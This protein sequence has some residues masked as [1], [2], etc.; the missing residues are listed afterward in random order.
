[1]LSNGY[2][3]WSGIDSLVSTPIYLVICFVFLFISKPT[4]TRCYWIKLA[5]RS[6]IR[7]TNLLGYDP[8][9]FVLN[10]TPCACGSF[11]MSIYNRSSFWR[12]YRGLKCV[13]LRCYFKPIFHSFM[14]LLL[15][16]I[17]SCIIATVALKS[18]P[19]CFT[20]FDLLYFIVG[21]DVCYKSFR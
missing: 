1:M 16:F 7:T 21:E 14:L 11:K 17:V 20:I 6:I 13:L 15:F 4:Q 10:G 8:L 5:A 9:S 2:K 18:V 19:E 12:R 3:G